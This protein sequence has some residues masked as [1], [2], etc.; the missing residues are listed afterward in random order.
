MEDELQIKLVEI[1]TSIQ[2]GI[3]KAGDFAVEQLP[4]IV[5]QFIVFGM[6]SNVTYSVIQI[7]S[8]VL[9]GFFSYKLFTSPK[10]KDDRGY[11]DADYGIGGCILAMLSFCS[12][13]AFLLGLRETLLVLFAPKVWLLMELANLIK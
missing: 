10:A 12:A 2:L 6:I 9:T 1:I 4:D 13:F 11:I 5:Q 3:G 7:V 8:A